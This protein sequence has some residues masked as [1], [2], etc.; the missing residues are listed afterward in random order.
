MGSD[1]P[2]FYLP[3]YYILLGIFYC[4][5]ARVFWIY[6]PMQISTRIVIEVVRRGIY[7]LLRIETREN[8]DN[9]KIV[10]K[11]DSSSKTE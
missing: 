5:F 7:T 4:I 10:G 11:T 1:K 6:F 2:Q 8:K 9:R 3:Y